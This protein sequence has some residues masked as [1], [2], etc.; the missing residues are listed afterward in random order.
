MVTHN[1]PAY[2]QPPRA[3]STWRT[4]RSPMIPTLMPDATRR[5]AKPTRK[6]D[7]SVTALGLSARNLMTKKAARP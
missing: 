1:R 7:E 4:A 2:H 5:E 6:L 3:S